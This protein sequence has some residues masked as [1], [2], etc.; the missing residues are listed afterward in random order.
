MALNNR[1]KLGITIA[2][3][4]LA[5]LTSVWIALLLLILAVFLIAWGQR[6]SARRHWLRDCRVAT[7]S[8]MRW[9]NWFEVLQR[10]LGEPQQRSP[11]TRLALLNLSAAGASDGYGARRRETDEGPCGGGADWAY[12]C[13]RAYLWVYTVG[14]KS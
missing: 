5:G 7:P 13:R 2:V 10:E 4:V 14:A 11:S 9:L 6:P 12:G 1:T 3:A 8:L